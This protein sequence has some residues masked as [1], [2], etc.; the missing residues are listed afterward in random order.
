MLIAMLSTLALAVLFVACANVAGLLT[1]RRPFARARWR[2]A[3]HRRR[4]RPARSSAGHREPADCP[5]GGVLGLAVGYAGMSLFR[6]TEI[7]SDLPIMLSFQMDRR[8]CCSASS[9]R[10]RVP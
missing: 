1:S 10:S 6:Q 5:A 3:R 7:P 4:T 8:R 9:W 2:C